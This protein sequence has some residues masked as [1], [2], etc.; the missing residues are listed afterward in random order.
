[1]VIDNDKNRPFYFMIWITYSKDNK[2]QVGNLKGVVGYV[3][4]KISLRVYARRHKQGSI[5]P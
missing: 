5:L 2:K 1:M 4:E 3:Y